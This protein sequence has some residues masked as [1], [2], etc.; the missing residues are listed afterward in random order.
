[1]LGTRGIWQG[2]W[3]A[4]AMHA[5]LS[6]ASHFDKDEWELYHVDADR[7]NRQTSPK[8]TRKCSSS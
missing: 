8:R 2:G 7:S 6:G 5:P 3:K 1:M 4:A